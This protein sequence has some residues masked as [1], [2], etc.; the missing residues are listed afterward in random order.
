MQEATGPTPTYAMCGKIWISFSDVVK[1]LIIAQPSI[2]PPGFLYP[3]LD[4]RSVYFMLMT[5]EPRSKK[6]L[7][8]L[9]AL[10][11]LRC[12][13]CKDPRDKIYEVFASLDTKQNIITPSYSKSVCR[14]YKYVVRFC[15]AA[16][17]PLGRLDFL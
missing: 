6:Q 16:Y 14:V 7:R 11:F 9:D 1:A 5:L 8:L 4:T 12:F 17:E 2:R 15:I 10:Q 13:D 3:P